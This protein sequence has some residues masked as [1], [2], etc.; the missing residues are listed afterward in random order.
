MTTKKP[1]QKKSAARKPAAKKPAAKKPAA[2]KPATKKAAAKKPAAKKPAAKKAAAKKP[3][4]KKAAAKKPAAKKPAARKAAA[5]KPA[6]KK[7]A[8]RKAAAKK[9]SAK[10]PAA[11]KAAAKKPAAKKPA[12][13]RAA[14]ADKAPPAPKPP[15]P[16]K[17]K[18]QDKVVYPHHG[19]AIIVKKEKQPVDGKRVDYF[20]LEVATDQLIVRVPVDRAEE[21]GVRPVISKN[22]A[23]KVFAVFRDEPQE[24]GSNWS[25]WYKVLTEKINSG[26]IYQ[27][28]EVVRDL[29]YAQQLKGISPALKRMLS[30]AHLILNSELRFALNLDEDET[31][32][33][34][35]RA[36]PKVEVPE[37]G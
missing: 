35:L 1:A 17:F 4:A 3:A 15:K 31:E 16:S 26:D 8:A 33:R 13:G 18:V 2:K 25:R 37:E 5:K 7:P 27:V 10:K 36:L 34:I 22:A 6:A 21:L 28:A 19:A 29:T 30:K 20:V 14:K 12:R 9:S 24:A 23:R 32:K 11:R